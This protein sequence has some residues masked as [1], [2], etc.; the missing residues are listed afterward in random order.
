MTLFFL[1]G[2]LGSSAAAHDPIGT[3]LPGVVYDT[4]VAVLVGPLAVAIHDRYVEEERV[5]W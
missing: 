1:L 5:D 4:A 2:A 3:L